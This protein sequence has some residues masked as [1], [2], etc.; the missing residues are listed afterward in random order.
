VVGGILS[1]IEPQLSIR[2]SEAA[3]TTAQ[4]RRS[5][6]IVGSVLL[7]LT[8]WN[9]YRGRVAV[10]A[11]L[12]SAGAVLLGIGVLFPTGAR[13]FHV[14]WMRLAAV[15]GYVNSRALLTL[16]YFLA[17]TPYGFV[18]RLLKRDPLRRRGSGEQSY[19]IARS[20]KTIEGAVRTFVLSLERF[21]HY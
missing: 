13:I 21:N 14:A 11:V 3:V 4:A 20:Y 5:T 6:F 10:V 15:F 8:V 12:G 18:S 9:L 17:V 1:L 2:R 19:W 7:V 16:M